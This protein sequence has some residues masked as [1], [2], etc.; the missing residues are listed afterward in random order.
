MKMKKSVAKVLTVLHGWGCSLGSNVRFRDEDEYDDDDVRTDTWSSAS[1]H[2]YASSVFC[3]GANRH[4]RKRQVSSSNSTD[5]EEVYLEEEEESGLGV[6][7]RSRKAYYPDFVRLRPL[8]PDARGRSYHRRPFPKRGCVRMTGRAG[9]PGL[10]Q[11]GVMLISMRHETNVLTSAQQ[12]RPAVSP[13][14]VVRLRRTYCDLNESTDASRG[15]TSGYSSDEESRLEQ[16]L[17]T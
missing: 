6:P 17:G 10:K 2:S 3:S 9:R 14:P 13:R 4:S 5:I 1:R 11:H 7:R 12:T 16:T 8:V 15:S